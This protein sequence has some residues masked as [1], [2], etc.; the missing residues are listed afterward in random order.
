M[1]KALFA[2]LIS[3]VPTLVHAQNCKEPEKKALAP[4]MKVVAQWS[5]DNWWVAHITSI[6]KGLINVLY[7]DNTRGTGKHTWDIVPYPDNDVTPCFK[8]GDKVV[9]AWKG[10]SWWKASIDTINGASADVT[11]S[12]GEKGNHRLSDMVRAP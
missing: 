10:D 2:V 7:S 4:G 1:K 12:D 11:Y 6:R 8:P 9:S 5:G 3:V